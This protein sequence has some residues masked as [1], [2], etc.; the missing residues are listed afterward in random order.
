MSDAG[1]EDGLGDDDLAAYQAQLLAILHAG[2][3]GHDM[4]PLIVAAS[5]PLAESLGDLDVTLVEVAAD[6]TR[7]W[8][9]RT[10]R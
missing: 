7:T 6:L 1:T 8:A 4:I 5:G 9:S 3:S 2:S 10:Q